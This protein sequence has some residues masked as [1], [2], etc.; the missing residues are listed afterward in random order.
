[1]R[2]ED[3]ARFGFYD[4]FCGIGAFHIAAR[5]YGGKCVGACDIDPFARETYEENHGLEPFP[6]IRRVKA[7]PPDTHFLFAGFPCPTFSLA[8]KSKLL[9]LGREHGLEDEERGQLIYEVI[10]LAETSEPPVIVLENVKHILSHDGGRTIET[11]RSAFESFGYSLVTGEPWVLDAQD[12]GVP[13]HRERVFIVL[14]H[15]A[16]AGLKVRKPVGGVPRERLVDILEPA[17]K[18]PE[19]YI[20]GPGTWKTLERHKEHHRQ[21]GNGFGY[22]LWDLEDETAVSATISARYH[23]D[24]AEALVPV[25]NSER[26]RRLMPEEVKRLMG[27]SDSFT[28]RRVSDTQAYRQLGNSIVVDV[29]TAVVGEIVAALEEKYGELPFEFAEQM[30]LEAMA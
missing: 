4:A 22:R 7:L 19:K 25:E 1:M 8:G 18:V 30:E 29:A 6:D 23:K 3:S 9:S 17:E 15:K 27:F 26:P 14:V 11:I 16:F 21:Q 12:F 2:R 20:L 28:F 24:G 10:R 5:T 13:Q